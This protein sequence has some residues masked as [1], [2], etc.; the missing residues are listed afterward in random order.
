MMINLQ[1]RKHTAK[2]TPAAAMET[3]FHLSLDLFCVGGQ[4]GYFWMANP[5]WEKVLGWTTAELRQRPWIEFVHP[6]DVEASLRADSLCE[7][8]DIVGFENRY[9]HKDGSY[10][11]LSWNMWQCHNGCRYAIAKDITEQKTIET[12]LSLLRSLTTAINDAP[13]LNSALEVTLRQVCETTGWEYGEVW[14]PNTDGTGIQCSCVKYNRLEKLRSFQV[15]EGFTFPAG[16]GIPGRV[17]AAKKPEWNQDISI[18][19]LSWSI[20]ANMARECG[21]KAG[22]GVPILVDDEVLAVLVF[23]T[24]ERRVEDQRLVKLVS[25]VAKQLG[26][27]MR[28]KQAED[29][30]RATNQTLQTLIATSPLGIVTLNADT[31]VTMWN[32]T[33]EKLFGWNEAEVLGRSFPCIPV[34]EQESFRLRFQAQLQGNV[35]TAL[36]LRRLKKDGSLIDV[37]LW[38]APLRDLDG[39]IIGSIGL[40]ADISDRVAAEKERQQLISLIEH[41]P[42]FISLAAI[43][44][45]I[46][47]INEAGQK[48]IGMDGE[49]NAQ[50]TQIFDY[51]MPE[52]RSEYQQHLLPTILDT[53]NWTG[54]YRFRNV[55]NNT[56]ISVHYNAFAIKDAQTGQPTAIATVTRDITPN[57]IAESALRESEARFRRLVDSNIIGVI[58]C[59]C[60]GN[61]TQAN[62]AFLETISRTR[63]ELVAGEIFWH[64]IT[65]LEYHA[66]DQKALEELRTSGVCTPF[67]KEYLRP[68]GSRVSVLIGAALVE[69][70]QDICVAFVLDIT[71]RKQMEQ[72][73]RQSKKRLRTVLENMP[74]M[75]DAVDEQG[76][77][78]VWN[79]ECERVTG[80]LSTEM[81]GNPQ[82]W[83]L[84]YPDESYR[85]SM[86]TLWESRNNNYRNWEWEITCKDGT[87]KTIAWSNISGKFPIPGWGQWA[88]GVDVTERK[89]AKAELQ[90]DNE[91]L[92]TKVAK[93][94]AELWNAQQRAEQEL[95]ERCRAEQALKRHAQMID[96]ANDTI[97]ICDLNNTIAYWNQG[98]QKLYGWTKEEAIG[99]TLHELLQTK[100]PQPLEAINQALYLFGY[101]QG[102]IIHTNRCGTEITVASR[103]TLWHDEWGEPSA[104]LEIN[105]D[106]T[107]QKRIEAEIKKLNED[108][109]T[110]NL[111]LNA[112]N[113]ELEAFCYSVS[114]DLRSPLRIINGFS[115]ALQEDYSDVLDEIGQDYLRRVCGATQRMGQLIDDLLSLSRITRSQME[116][117]T[118][119]L[120]AIAQSVTLDLQSTQPDR[121]VEFLIA[122]N[123][124]VQG[125]A[126]LLRV[127]LENL[128]SNAWK[129]TSKHPQ[130]RIEFGALEPAK[131]EQS[132]SGTVENG[133]NLS[134]SP[135]PALPPSLKTYFVRDDGAGFNMSY[136]EKLFAPFQRLHTMTEFEGNGIGLATVQRIIHRHGG[137]I[138][139]KGEV[140][141]GAT[142]YFTLNG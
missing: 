133:K 41:S 123:L 126:K 51:L 2:L 92:E 91:E 82:A 75:L 84:L 20:R 114:H 19:P 89:R 127:A 105:N 50:A 29:T 42:D 142:F 43:N 132:E 21:I 121:Q 49:R 3:F 17:W 27:L 30:L 8:Q 96:L 31:K 109:A 140:E 119:D 99:K 18:Q 4:D 69:E 95:I 66:L 122:P 53:G 59:D 70:S 108:L 57:L 14:I 63:E 118:V 72:A 13:D 73:L 37:S 98:A 100:F 9:R 65:P 103:W 78:I 83:E 22:F 58:V 111:E 35:E 94:T 39:N 137:Q 32:S 45:D 104:I 46:L 25:A 38:T 60:K 1:V 80:Y 62:D 12:E 115:I 134:P 138:W 36:E 52:D 117:A 68:D 33:A 88:I 116:F 110:R 86:L 40:F 107:A 135:P 136:A 129:Y 131:V 77:I 125:D 61:I 47:Y 64:E 34:E 76:N 120:S 79:R 15:S 11:W 23:F 67:E 7:Q 93:R 85:A 10:R 71:E 74:V 48:L 6:E 97:M 141:K 130:A 87:V 112:A 139:A 101:W 55:K 106:I 16:I 44:G 28:R 56:P 124:Q 5:A 24:V 128:L 102:E 113:K 81:V 90:K 26:S 54:E